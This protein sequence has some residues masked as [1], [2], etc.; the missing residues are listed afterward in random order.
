[1]PPAPSS[2]QLFYP[3]FSPNIS[4]SLL[5]S[6]VFTSSRFLLH[7]IT[8][9][10]LSSPPLPPIL[11]ASLTPLK[12][13]DKSWQGWLATQR[14]WLLTGCTRRGR[15][16]RGEGSQVRQ[17][18]F[19]L[20]YARSF[21]VDQGNVGWLERREREEEV[22][23]RGEGKVGRVKGRVRGWERR[24]KRKRRIRIRIF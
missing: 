13:W 8:S 19:L 1:M 23:V 17:V 10:S 16:E 18:T 7:S 2:H 20:R 11:R 22:R 21:C 3:L 9:T 15:G 4:F 12:F 24:R 5:S 6:S 14:I